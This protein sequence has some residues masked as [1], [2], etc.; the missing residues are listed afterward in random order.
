MRTDEP[1]AV[2]P[3]PG[4][5][6]FQYHDSGMT[7][8]GMKPGAAGEPSTAPPVPASGPD[9]PLVTSPY[10]AYYNASSFHV[11][12]LDTLAGA[13][14]GLYQGDDPDPMMGGITGDQV[15]KSGAGEGHAN[16]FAHPNSAGIGGSEGRP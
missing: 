6:S 15:G 12:P 4:W 3:I 1:G 14:A 7:A 11:S 2:T 5:T 10:G 16:H 13:Q 9:R 8:P